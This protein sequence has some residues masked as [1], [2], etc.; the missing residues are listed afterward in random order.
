M[1]ASTI[2]ALLESSVAHAAPNEQDAV[3]LEAGIYQH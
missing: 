1:R 2:I 3:A